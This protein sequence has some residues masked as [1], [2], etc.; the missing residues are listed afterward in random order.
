MKRYFLLLLALTFPVTSSAREYMGYEVVSFPF[1][2]AG[3]EVVKLPITA[4]GPIPA[5]TRKLKVEV[6]GFSVGPSAKNP[7]A[8]VLSWHFGFTAKRLKPLE[9]VEIAEVFP[10]KTVNTLVFDASPT[11]E[12]GYWKGGVIAVPAGP[13]TTPWLYDTEASIFVFR[14]SVREKGKRPIVLYQPAWFS[15]EAKDV[16]RLQVARIAEN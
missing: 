1:T 6:A 13:Q 3:G 7:K 9:S 2:L 11:L 15:K 14:F 4:A 10:S 16:F 5:E 8:P 12:S